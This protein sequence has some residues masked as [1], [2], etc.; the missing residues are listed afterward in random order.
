MSIQDP[1]RASATRPTS[2]QVAEAYADAAI[3]AGASGVYVEVAWRENSLRV[4]PMD[5]AETPED[6]PAFVSP[7]QT[8]HYDWCREHGVT[9]VGWGPE[10]TRA[11]IVR[12][13]LESGLAEAW[14]DRVC[15]IVD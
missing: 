9:C 6:I 3:L 10:S 5:P 1:R 12:L 2:R 15:L 14:I 4:V 13:A 11:D 7:P 8:V